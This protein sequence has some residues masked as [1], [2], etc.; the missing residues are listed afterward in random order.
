MNKFSKWISNHTK[1]VLILTVI[2]ILPA[3][4][5]IINTRI[6]YD[7]LSY[8]PQ[9]LDSTKGQKVL[10][11]VYS[12]AA[13][14]MLIIEGM[15]DKDVVELKDKIKNVKGV[16][17]AIWVDDALDISVPKD[18]LPDVVKNQLFNGDTTMVIIKYNNSSASESTLNAIGEIKSMT[19]KQCF[20]S[21]MSAILKDT[22]D[23]ADK[24]TPF[25][26]ILAVII[27]LIVLLISMEST[28]V[29]IIFLVSIGIGI[30]FNLGTNI[31]FG[32]ISYITKALAAVLQLGVTM[33]YSIFLMHRYEE[34]L[35]RF[36]NK[37][38]AMS[39]AI[40]TT[41][42]SISGSS[43]TTIA[44]FLALCAMDL[45]L[46]KD[47]GIVMAKGVVLG[48]ICSVTV[49]PSLILTFDKLIHR[50]KHKTIIPTFDKLSKVVTTH[51]KIFI[52]VFLVL[53]VPA[54]FGSRNAKV[55]YNLDETLPK[56][57]PSIVATNKLKDKFNMMTTHFILVNDEAKP[58]KIKEMTN[59]IE[60]IKGITSVISY[61]KLIGPAIPEEFIP[62]DIREIF[63]KGGYNLILANSEYK[64]AKDEENEQID[65]IISLVKGYDKNALVAGEGPLTKDLITTSDKDFKMVSVYS[66]I[67][68]FLII[69]I[70][71]KSISVPILLVA[72]IEFAIFI[73][74]GIPYYT[75][76]EIPFVASIVIGTIQ[77]GATVDYAILMTSRF[78]EELRKG[79]TKQEAILIAVKGS[80]KSI[81]TS[82]LTFFGATGAVAMVSDMALIRSLCFLISR[83]ALISMAV[84]L[85][86][87]PSFLLVSEGLINKTSIKWRES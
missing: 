64:A 67:A 52:G 79:H 54:I 78:R 83:G 16:E 26:V 25:Y 10:D 48:V 69:L 68:I 22:K 82:G 65:E 34:E 32:E 61:D 31:I 43:L 66:I 75:G 2:L 50:Y 41:M 86:I 30:L 11:D 73:N 13:T 39:E 59:K 84:I 4:F 9:D 56:D 28:F 8:L 85:S 38:D 58:Y 23:L 19:N 51:Y 87:L 45:T 24:E 12:D 57:M 17:N 62:K 60:D 27:S 71:F 76:N 40:S 5:G 70:V 15:K 47:I 63:K 42:L 74:M 21:G 20:L 44:G 1:I 72:A 46:G 29:P 7:I 55:Y 77:L 18:M 37:K 36:E 53:L 49:L 6:N 80:A 33:D 3:T 35:T 14:S 81:V